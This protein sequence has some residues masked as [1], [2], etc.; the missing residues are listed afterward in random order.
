V[1][2]QIPG[3]CLAVFGCSDWVSN[4]K[5]PLLGNRWLFLNTV[6]WCLDQDEALDIPPKPLEMYA[7]NASRHEFIL[8]TLNFLLLPMGLFFMGALIFLARRN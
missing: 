7:V 1:G 5:L 3:G 2:I 6:K 8:L 4:A